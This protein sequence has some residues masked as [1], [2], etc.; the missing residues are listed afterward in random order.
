MPSAESDARIRWVTD[1]VVEWGI[2]RFATVAREHGVVPVML[3]LNAVID[4]VPAEVPHL[5]AIRKAGLP[6]IDL[7][8]VYPEAGRAALRV[9]EYDEHPNPTGNRLVADRLYPELVT[10]LQSA[11]I[12]EKR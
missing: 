4:D 10:F 7:F 3:A 5:P 8:D 9:S 1:D 2:Q 12:V 11:A 6:L